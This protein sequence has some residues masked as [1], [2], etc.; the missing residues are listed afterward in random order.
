MTCLAAA[1][2]GTVL[3]IRDVIWQSCSHLLLL[4]R[5]GLQL[6]REEY[7]QSASQFQVK[8]IEANGA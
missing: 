3:D 2:G 4:K 6:L 7:L 5:C 8:S 1:K